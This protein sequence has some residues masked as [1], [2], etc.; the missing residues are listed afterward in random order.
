[1]FIYFVKSY[2]WYTIF[3]S[4]N[5]ID[6]GMVNINSLSYVLN[7]FLFL[8]IEMNGAIILLSKFAIVIPH[9]K[10]YSYSCYTIILFCE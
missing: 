10:I 3:D 6:H 7:L 5:K 1:M 2:N 4:L 9:C 8:Q